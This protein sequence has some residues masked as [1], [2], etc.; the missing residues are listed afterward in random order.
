MRFPRSI[1]GGFSV[2]RQYRIKMILSIAVSWTVI[3]MFFFIF[4][5]LTSGPSKSALFP[6]KTIVTIL[7]REVNV[8]FI[9]LCMGYALVFLLKNMLRNS[10]V[11]TNILLKTLILIIA[12]LGV[13]F[14]IHTT[15]V[16]LIDKKSF[17]IAVNSF[18]TH[19]FQGTWLLEKMPEW[20]I[21]F[22]LTQ[23][24]IEFIEKYSPG[25]FFAIFFGKYLK[26]KNEY[27]IIMF[28]DLKN[29]TPIAEKM[30]NTHYFRFIREFIYHIST[31]L[32]EYGGRIYQYVGDEIIVSWPAKQKNYKNCIQALITARKNIEKNGDRF[33]R[34]YGF[35]PEFKVGIHYGEVTIGEIGVIKKDLAMSGDAMNTTARIRDTCSELN[36]KFI[37]S[38]EF[39]EKS[40][41]TDWQ[42]ETLGG[43]ELKGKNVS[44][45]LFALK[46]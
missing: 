46:I 9:S 39:I 38:K 11:F 8:F 6:N 35:L 18:Y 4:R 10:S 26:P 27:L 33:R 25:I 41:L 3:D 17:A 13:N 32:L 43:F 24:I 30:D 20:F 31:A 29:S 37:V 12:A 22:I 23:I 28:I 40:N 15:Y 34:E 2:I 19:T 14:F 42:T 21:L 1:G 16:V 36:Q 5:I 44:T 45:E 7:L